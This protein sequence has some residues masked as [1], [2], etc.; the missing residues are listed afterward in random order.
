M[1]IS[2]AGLPACKI[3]ATLPLR[4]L[5]VTHYFPPEITAPA[6]RWGETARFWSAQGAKVTVLTCLPNYPTGQ[7]DPR[8]RGIDECIEWVD[9]VEVIRVRTL[10]ATE[11]SAAVRFLSQL[12]FYVNGKYSLR[13]RNSFDVVVGTSPPLT[14]AELASHLARQRGIP[15][16]MEVRDLWPDVIKD[17]GI[18]E[19][20]PLMGLLYRWEKR[21]YRQAS[22]IVTVT[23][24]FLPILQEK[25]VE[26]DRLSVVPPGVLTGPGRTKAATEA[27]R[28]LGLE[29]KTVALYLGN[30]GISQGLDAI[31][32]AAN[33]LDPSVHLLMVGDGWEKP[34]LIEQAQRL[35][36]SNITFSDAV[37][38]EQTQEIYDAADL[39]LVPLRGSGLM[40]H[41]LPSKLLE[42]LGSG[43]P[44]L[45]NIGGEGARIVR[46]NEAGI[47]LDE[48]SP[49]SVAEALNNWG[50]SSERWEAGGARA[51][52][53]VQKHFDRQRLAEDYLEIIKRVVRQDGHP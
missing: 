43:R 5:V 4:V 2:A 1:N 45:T 32:A 10:P 9:G 44:V 28:R 49:A 46:E 40:Q 51:R 19:A 30:H 11:R 25:G 47:V 15:F 18:G 16:V 29:G 41:F 35:G 27:K 48:Y 36:L 38:K 7:I 17:T 24:S 50:A 12:A 22:H 53:Y 23:P 31:V 37:P 34:G 26:S 13:S 42:V 33:N 14:A 39:C 6:F 3:A 8:Y 52:T 20:R 21:L